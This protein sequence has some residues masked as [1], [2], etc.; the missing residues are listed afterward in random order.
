M[1]AAGRVGPGGESDRAGGAFSPAIAHTAR[2][3][4][5]G[6]KERGLGGV[7]GRGGGVVGGGAAAERGEEGLGLGVGVGE[8]EGEGPGRLVEWGQV[9]SPTVLAG[10]F[11]QIGR[12]SCRERVSSPV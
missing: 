1:R 4:P 11:P 6:D 10:H 2:A 5:G 12:A 9:G 7:G 8:E 3:I